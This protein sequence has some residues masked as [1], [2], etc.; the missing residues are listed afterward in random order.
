MEVLKARMTAPISQMKRLAVSTHTA[1]QT[2]L[3]WQLDTVSLPG[4]SLLPLLIPHSFLV[5]PQ[6][7]QL[8]VE[9]GRAMGRVPRI[10]SRWWS[11]RCRIMGP[12]GK[13]LGA[14]AAHGG[15]KV[16]IVCPVS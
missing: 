5:G 11:S 1:G 4:P 7:R 9:I 10:G 16:V 8:G 15:G 6:S 2:E 12:P 13:A 3:T 14:G